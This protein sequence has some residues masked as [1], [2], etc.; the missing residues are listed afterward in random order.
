M[1][2]KAR[3][4]GEREVRTF[5]DLNHGANVL[6]G[7]A[8]DSPRGSYYT[9]MASLLL[10]AFTFE[11]YLNHLGDKTFPFWKKIE[12]IRVMD[13]YSLL[14]AHFKIDVDWGGRPHQ[15]LKQLFRFRNSIAHGK[16]VVV[17]GERIVDAE[18]EPHDLMPQAHWEEFCTWENADRVRTDVSAVVTQMHDAAGLGGY[19]FI[20][21]AAVGGLSIVE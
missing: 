7:I 2:K 1:A 9:L 14:C 17:V 16:S 20:P 8:K 11:A 4:K 13:K 21:G 18:A 12:S 6:F 5:A 15:T 19:P 10:S 3:F